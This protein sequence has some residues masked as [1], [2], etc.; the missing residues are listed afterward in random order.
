MKN[1][2]Y[3]HNKR[4]ETSLI[5]INHPYFFLLLLIVIILVLSYTT[6]TDP[7][8]QRVANGT[9][10][11]LAINFLLVHLHNMYSNKKNY[12]KRD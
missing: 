7:F 5:D 10:V 12:K 6:F 8:N 4:K 1:K 2:I 3:K 11:L 9:M